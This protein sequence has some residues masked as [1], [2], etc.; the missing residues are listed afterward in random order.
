MYYNG[1]GVPRNEA[2]AI[3]WYRKAAEQGDATAQSLVGHCYDTGAG[4]AKNPSEAIKWYRKAAYQNDHLSQWSVSSMYSTGVGVPKDAIESL[5][6]LYVSAASGNP[7][8][9]KWRDL[10]E[11]KLRSD[12]PSAVLIAQQRSKEIAREIEAAMTKPENS[13]SGSATGKSPRPESIKGTGTGSIISAQGLILTAAHVVQGASEIQVR[14]TN[15]VTSAKVVRIDKSN[16]IAVLKLLSGKYKP[17]AVSSSQN[18]R[19][20]QAVATIG[21]PNIDIQGLSEAAPAGWTG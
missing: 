2:E 9:V 20:G 3:R 8:Y 10:D 13:D 17:L 1:D 11:R 5:A 14:T 21:F 6:W 19:L 15:G 7:D 12:N 18:I 4:V 16:D